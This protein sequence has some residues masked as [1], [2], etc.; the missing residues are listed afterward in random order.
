MRIFFSFLFLFFCFF[1]ATSK[2]LTDFLRSHVYQVYDEISLPSGLVTMVKFPLMSDHLN[3]LI[4]SPSFSPRELQIRPDEH[5]FSWHMRFEPIE[6]G[7]H[8]LFRAII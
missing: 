7:V 1:F 4:G 8:G 3:A 5:S 6:T 2:L